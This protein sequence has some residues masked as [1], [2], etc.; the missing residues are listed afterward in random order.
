MFKEDEKSSKESAGYRK[1]DVSENFASLEEEEERTLRLMIG[2]K[3]VDKEREGER[4][5]KWSSSTRFGAGET[6]KKQ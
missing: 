1:R 4:K 5:L 2:V 3:S 6:L